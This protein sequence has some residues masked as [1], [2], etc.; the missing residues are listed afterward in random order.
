MEIEQNLTGKMMSVVKLA[1]HWQSSMPKKPGRRDENGEQRQWEGLLA[2]LEKFSRFANDYDKLLR[3]APLPNQRFI[4]NDG[5]QRLLK[6]FDVLSRASEQRRGAVTRDS[7]AFYLAQA[8]DKLS[9]YC[10]RWQPGGKYPA[11]YVTLKTPVVYFEKSFH[12][13]RSLYAPEIP[14]VSIPLTDYNDPNRWLALA[15]E[16]GHH[17]FWN[18]LKGLEDVERLHLD[19]YTA[20]AEPWQQAEGEILQPWGLWLEEIF[21][22]VCGVLLAG[23]TYVISSQNLAAEWI[24]DVDDFAGNDN[25]HPSL[26][27]RPWIAYEVLCRVMEP[28]E[29]AKSLLNRIAERWI[30]FCGDAPTLKCNCGNRGEVSLDDLRMEAGKVVDILLNKPIWPNNQR[31]RDL[32][33]Y[34]NQELDLETLEPLPPLSQEISRTAG[35]QAEDIPQSIAA[36]WNFIQIKLVNDQRKSPVEKEDPKTLWNALV[37]LSL[38]DEHGHWPLSAGHA[39]QVHWW[40]PWAKLHTH[41]PAT[42]S[43]RFW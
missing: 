1:G 39:P 29:D 36:V 6:N 24:R 22:D 21:A 5:A 25:E 35:P 43:I 27:L 28:T 20:L 30:A 42:G 14:V 16:M 18:A 4:V 15:H 19:M 10:S 12:I 23:P 26:Y 3:R 9:S 37:S 13:S 38:E 31:L 40:A 33:R 7:L 41:D 17:I 32:I 34:E 2:L 8:E 11:S